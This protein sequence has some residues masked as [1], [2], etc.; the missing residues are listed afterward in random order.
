MFNETQPNTLDELITFIDEISLGIKHIGGRDSLNDY[1]RGQYDMMVR[2]QLKLKC[3]GDSE[4]ASED[5]LGDDE[6]LK[7]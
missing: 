2:L 3:I 1:G 7:S 4:K 5:A 6:A